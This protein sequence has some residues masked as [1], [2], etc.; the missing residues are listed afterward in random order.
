MFPLW[1]QPG[2]DNV[3]LSQGKKVSLTYYGIIYRKII[4]ESATNSSACTGGC[5]HATHV[6]TYYTHSDLW[7]S[8][9]ANSL[10]SLQFFFN[11]APINLWTA[12]MKQ[13]YVLYPCQ[14]QSQDPVIILKIQMT[15]LLL[16]LKCHVR[17]T[18]WIKCTHMNITENN[19]A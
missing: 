7:H 6:N 18:N 16:V 9:Q 15:A 11:T 2:S 1:K 8:W 17:G 4:R 3:L 10:C 13:T 14:P 12:T 19:M 5:D